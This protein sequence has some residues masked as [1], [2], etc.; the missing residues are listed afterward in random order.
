MGRDAET[1]IDARDFSRAGLARL[2]EA[3]AARFQGDLTLRAAIDSVLGP[4]VSNWDEFEYLKPESYQLLVATLGPRFEALLALQPSDA[5]PQCEALLVD[6][7]SV[8]PRLH[9]G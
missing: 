3:L 8:G 9:W 7:A 2:R 4:L 6:W 5:K 1:V